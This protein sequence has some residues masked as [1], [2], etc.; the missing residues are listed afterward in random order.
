[1]KYD[2]EPK[3][4]EEIGISDDALDETFEEESDDEE[5]DDFGNDD[6]EKEWE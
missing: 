6:N 4:D 2:D 5:D 3:H 1:M